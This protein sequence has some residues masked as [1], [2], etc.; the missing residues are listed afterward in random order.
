ML[1]CGRIS[2]YNAAPTIS[3]PDPLARFMGLALTRRLTVRGFLVFDHADRQEEFLRDMR[4]WLKSGEVRY[5]EDI[6]EGIEK[7]VEAFQGLMRGKNRGKLIVKVGD[8]PTRG[9]MPTM[10]R[11]PIDRGS[12]ETRLPNEP[13][14]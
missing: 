8:D 11:V 6:V 4:A 10:D 3:G 7:T 1:V 14:E 13:G 12:T 2:A 5:R 9:G